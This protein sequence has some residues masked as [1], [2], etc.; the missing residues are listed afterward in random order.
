MA[1]NFFIGDVVEI[2]LHI[3]THW[4]TAIAII[5]KL[6]DENGYYTIGYITKKLIGHIG[7]AS[8]DNIKFTRHDSWKDQE[9]EL[10]KQLYL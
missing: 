2:Y 5:L 8:G 3:D 9:V 6:E 7:F 1:H 4:I 10:Y